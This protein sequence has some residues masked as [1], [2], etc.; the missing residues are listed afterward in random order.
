[1]K[2][3]KIWSMMMLA[4]MTMSVATSCGGDDDVINNNP[5]S[6]DLIIKASGKWMCTQSVD[7]QGGQSYQ[8]LM[9]GK[10]ITINPNG[11]YTSTAPTF[12]YNGTYTVSG[13][14]I[15]AHS[16]AGGTFLINVTISGD[17]MT[18]DGTANNGVTFRYIFEREGT[19]VP[20]T[21]DFTKELVAG[22]FQWQVFS[23][24]II[25]G[26]NNL[27]HK[28]KCI[29]FNEDGTCFGFSLMENAW[30][31]NNGRI[32]TYYKQTNEPMF[33]YTLLSNNENEINVRIDGTLDDNLQ[34]QV[35]LRKIPRYD[36]V[37]DDYI[38]KEEI[39]DIYNGCYEY[40]AS[41]E[42]LQLKLESIRTNPATV[43][44][45]TSTN[46]QVRETWN[47]AYKAIRLI[48]T[49]LNNDEQISKVMDSQTYVRVTAEMKALR[50]FIYYNLAMLWGNVPLV[51][52]VLTVDE[53]YNIS[54]SAQEEVY[55]FAYEQLSS[56]I[57]N[58]PESNSENGRLYFNI[59]AGKMLAAELAM[60][61]GNKSQAITLLNQID[62]S[63]YSTTRATTS[64]PDNPFIWA[65][66]VQENTYTPIYTLM[67]HQLFLYEL[68]GN[69]E[70][71]ILPS[72]NGNT[73]NS[74]IES[75]W[76]SSN[77]LEYG[78][79]ATLKR[80]GKAQA[81]TGCYDNELFMPFP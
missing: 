80:L 39:L 28:D 3:L 17:R 41:F 34:V 42:T 77:F 47:S 63:S 58:L 19:G 12:G 66:H 55:K 81:V 40:C 71:L 32:E 56:V 33:V 29:Y 2:K 24:N 6:D 1:M 72:T 38:T 54:Q 76:K 75:L 69:K 78:Y 9:V 67:H 26:N 49:L 53:S 4:A 22:N 7:V 61:M 37:T 13:N 14:K 60:S 65:I 31:L 73:D 51:T 48:N 43:H 20:E 11:T 70:G 44:I 23:V 18:W 15:T 21:K 50:A 68:T 46:N 36:T 45:L 52:E 5:T 30:R 59:D 35:V 25:R 10:E 74:S 16:D 62:K 57:K 27:I 79:W 8:G 64:S